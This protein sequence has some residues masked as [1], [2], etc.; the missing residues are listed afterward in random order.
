MPLKHTKSP[1]LS[2]I[3]VI[4]LVIIYESVMFIRYHS[5][6]VAIRNGADILLKRLLSEIGFYGLE[7]GIVLFLMVFILVKWL[8][9]IHFNEH[10]LKLVSIPVMAGEGLIYALLIFYILIHLNMSYAPVNS[11]DHALNIAYSCGAG[12]YEELVFRA[13][14]M[15]GLYL[16]I[17]SLGKNEWL[18]WVSAILISTAVFVTLHYVGEFKYAFEWHSF[19]VRFAVSVILSLVFLFRG[20]AVAAYTHTFYNLSLIYLGGLIP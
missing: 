17:Q 7:A 18:S 1:L 19:W 5:E 13:I 15:Y 2:F 20:F 16:M 14:I 8:H 11:S 12:V 10:E 3:A 4:P 9:N 6:S